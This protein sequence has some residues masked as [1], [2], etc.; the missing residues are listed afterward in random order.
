MNNWICTIVLFLCLL[1]CAGPALAADTTDVFGVWASMTLQG[2]FKFLSPAGDKIVWLIMNQSRTREDSPEGTRFSEN[3]LF[4]QVGYEINDRAS[5]WLGYV[6]N[7]A[8]PLNEAA[9]QESRPYQDFLWVQDI[10]DFRFLSRTRFEQ[11]VNLANGDTG[12][13]PR[14]FFQISYPM[15]FLEGLSAYL[16][17]EVLF[18]LDKSSFGK[19]GF[20]ENRILAGLSYQ[21]TERVGFDLGYLGQYVDN[22]SGNNLFTHNLQANL[23]L[24][25]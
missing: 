15:R 2:D 16:G 1:R 5:I 25:F 14:Q 21:F 4:S 24:A 8:H 17:D 6:H 12:Y 23:R 13:R 3:L 9:F 11:R 20:S 22:A 19:Q 7:W 10:D 18:Y